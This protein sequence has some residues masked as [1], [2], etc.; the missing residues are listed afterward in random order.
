MYILLLLYTHTRIYI[1]SFR[2]KHAPTNVYFSSDHGNSQLFLPY[3]YYYTTA[4]HEINSE[5][6]FIFSYDRFNR[7]VFTH[8]L[9]S[10]IYVHYLYVFLAIHNGYTLG[11]QS[12][13]IFVILYSILLVEI[14]YYYNS[15]RK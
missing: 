3:T 8:L 15:V 2:L 10:C 5:Q 7:K 14:L 4:L 1:E 9:L 13:N 12:P 6:F 11:D